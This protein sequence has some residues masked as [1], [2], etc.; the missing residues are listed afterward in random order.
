V[1]NVFLSGCVVAYVV[2]VPNN[3]LQKSD[4]RA[5]CTNS[6]DFERVNETSNGANLEFLPKFYSFMD[7]LLCS[8]K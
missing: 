7:V 6:E 1:G 8:E 2:R 3:C 5:K 4:M